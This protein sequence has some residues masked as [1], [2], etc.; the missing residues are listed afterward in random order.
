MSRRS[1]V[2]NWVEYAAAWPWLK[3]L[4]WMPLPAARLLA[5]LLG[6]TV[7][8]LTPKWRDVADR[9]LRLAFPDMTQSRRAEITRGVYRHLARVLLSTARLPRIRADNINQWLVYEGYEH[10]TEAHKKGRGVMFLTAH[11]GDWEISA[12][13][14]CLYGH[15]MHVVGRP[16]DNPYLD[17]Y[18]EGRRVVSGNRLIRKQEFGRQALRALGAKEAVGVLVDQNAAGDDGVFVDFFGHKASATSGQVRIAMRTGTPM[19]PGFAFWNEQR[20][21]YILRFSAPVE[22]ANT[23]EPEAD[24]LEN[25][26]RCQKVIEQAIREYPDQWLWIHRR[27]KTRP[28]G[29]PDLY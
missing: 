6:A 23:G 16:L 29:E 1:P 17:R 7:H 5:R 8:A 18:V 20:G 2:R 4:E 28:P 27:W 3:A 25:T 10:Y 12:H 14:H 13:G 22:M 24:L 15:P 21:I 26:Q 9:N 11:L 19:I